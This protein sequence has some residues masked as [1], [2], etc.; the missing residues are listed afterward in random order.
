[1]LPPAIDPWLGG[2][3]FW[4]ALEDDLLVLDEGM[5]TSRLSAV[6]GWD[7]VG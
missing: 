5:V 3:V 2:K 7:A 6:I 1:M 4:R